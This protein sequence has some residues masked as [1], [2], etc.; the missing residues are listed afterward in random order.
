MENINIKSGKLFLPAVGEFFKK[1]RERKGIKQEAVTNILGISRSNIAKYENGD[2]DIPT[3]K[4]AELC[5]M[6][7][8]KVADC[9]K[10][11]D[12]EIGFAD[13]S[14]IATESS[15]LTTQ[16]M[17]FASDIPLIQA[18]ESV[19]QE[20][21]FTKLIDATAYFMRWG[22]G[23]RFYS[24]EKKEDLTNNFAFF[25]IEFIKLNEPDKAR[26]ERLV[27]YCNAMLE[28]YNKRQ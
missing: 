28:E 4:V 21:E 6:Y 2:I 10:R 26:R 22:L 1:H 19:I 13:V 16:Y 27:K 7:E 25:M 12:A 18:D 24:Y 17:A 20:E 5:Q 14:K 11:I 23:E 8:C 3:S 9:G 15:F